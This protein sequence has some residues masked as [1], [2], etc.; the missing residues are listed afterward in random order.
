MFHVKHWKMGG[1]TMKVRNITSA[2]GNKI[3]NQFIIMDEL[4]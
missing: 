1:Y 3:A 4:S 2:K